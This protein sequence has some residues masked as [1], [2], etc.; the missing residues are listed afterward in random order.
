MGRGASEL[1]LEQK[2]GPPHQGLW[3]M[4]GRTSQ[5]PV[6]QTLLEVNAIAK[7]LHHF[8]PKH[9]KQRGTNGGLNREKDPP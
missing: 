2:T 8:I 6:P 7:L 9:R 5:F 4:Q 3:A 1:N